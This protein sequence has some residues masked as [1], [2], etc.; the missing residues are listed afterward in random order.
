ML[1]DS[2]R[3][4]ATNKGVKNCTEGLIPKV[5][6]LVI[7]YLRQGE[8]QSMLSGY[9]IHSR[10]SE[11]NC[12]CYQSACAHTEMPVVQHERLDC[13]QRVRVSNCARTIMKCDTR[14]KRKCWGTALR[15]DNVQS[16]RQHT[17]NELGA[18]R[19][20]RFTKGL[21]ICNLKTNRLSVASNRRRKTLASRL[22]TGRG[23]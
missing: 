1:D 18:T 12:V 9:E 13:R 20:R 14:H 4:R 2:T 11:P 7:I 3:P 6:L 5:F 19:A 15:G 16:L 10:S 21:A 8:S 22:T 17:S 23:M